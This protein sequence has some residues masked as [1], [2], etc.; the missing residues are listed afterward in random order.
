MVYR[1]NGRRYFTPSAAWTAVAR[2]RINA[3][4]E[5][6]KDDLFGSG[7]LDYTPG[8]TCHY[9][10]VEHYPVLLKRLTRFLKHCERTTTP[11]RVRA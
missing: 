7:P 5:C 3:R 6:E 8:S 2:A 4:C 1:A 10:R 11:R 9:H